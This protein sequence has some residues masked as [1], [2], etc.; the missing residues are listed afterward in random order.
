MTE[1]VRYPRPAVLERI[2]IDRPTVIEASAGTGKTYTLEHLV[3]ELLLRGEASIEE[4]LI[5]TFTEKAT[6]E[7]RQRVRD[8]IGQLLRA[9][10]GDAGLAAAG[11]SAWMLDDEARRRLR[12]AFMRFDR[13]PISTI[14]GFCQRVLGEHAFY[15]GGLFA[16]ELVDG[17]SLFERAL[18]AEVREALAGEGALRE[19]LEAGFGAGDPTRLEG[20]LFGWFQERGRPMPDPPEP[21]SSV[22]LLVH[23]LLPR[24][25][26][27]LESLKRRTGQLDFDDL[28]LRLH[29]ALHGPGGDA[30]A[31]R[32]R[33]MYRHCLVDEFQDT[34]RVQWDIFR[35][36]FLTEEGGHGLFVIGDPKQAIY[37]FRGGDIHTYLAARDALAD[38]GERVPLLDNYR[39]TE[40]AVAAQNLLFGEGFF[41]GDIRYEP[42]RCGNPAR[43]LEND[44]GQEVPP[45]VL[46]QV[47]DRKRLTA[48]GIRTTFA[49]F[50]AREIR[51]IVTDGALRSGERETA[52]PFAYSDVH[53]LTRTG[54]EAAEVG[55][56]LRRH[57]VP[58]A[59]FKQEGLLQT[60]E[61][62]HVR[63]V[64]R[65]VADPGDRARRL[66]A[67]LTP[68]FGVRLEDLSEVREAEETH[69]LVARLHRWKVLAD[70]HDYVGLFRDL[71]EQ[72][73]LVRREVFLE[74]SERAL[75]NYLHLFELLL[76]QAH[77]RRRGL[78]E[79]VAH[80]S[81][82]IERRA[83]PA[84]EDANVQRL[85]SE[86]DAVQILTMHKAKGLEAK[87]VFVA[88]G[89][90]SRPGHGDEPR[91]CH[92]DGVREAW[93]GAAPDEVEEAIRRE[94][95][96]EDERLL[97]VAVTRA[98]A[99]LY[100]PYL[101]PPARDRD[102]ARL[103]C[104]FGRMNGCYKRLNDRLVGL[105]EREAAPAT[106]FART[107][108]WVGGAPASEPAEAAPEAGASAGPW[109]PPQALLEPL[110]D[111]GEGLHALRA[112][113]A[114]PL[115]TSYTRLKSGQGGGYVAPEAEGES[116]TGETHDLTPPEADP[117]G[118][119]GGSGVGVFLH[120]VLEALD[121]E[122]VREADDV[123]GWAAREEVR[124]AFRASARRN[125][126]NVAHVPEA[127][128]LVFGALRVPVDVGPLVLPSGLCGL[129]HR[130]AEMS[131]HYPLPEQGHPLLCEPRP[132]PDRWPFEVRRGYVRGVVD[133]VFE[134]EGRLYFL[135]WKSDRLPSWS[136]AMVAQ[137]V[138]RNYTLQARLYALGVLRLL[139][140]RTAEDYEARFGG[141]LYC[142][143]RGMDGS[144]AA[145]HFERPSWD[146]VLGWESALRAEHAFGYR[147]GRGEAT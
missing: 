72:S 33:S 9:R 81:A 48:D 125:G 130:V 117:S 86:R 58:H 116:F 93:L 20:D 67:W 141:L 55:E 106:L 25:R 28:L 57:G 26:E 123:D 92:R 110:A 120:E 88:G 76:A 42:V 139:D 134:H 131:F 19:V 138:E 11:D 31:E 56:A 127:Q 10:P 83:A 135:D 146:D 2:R 124:A 133:L 53:V 103:E 6:R 8:T 70:A 29:E 77:R 41:E 98:K 95:R 12:D 79:L 49:E 104:T 14:H 143:L 7:M 100:L 119:P 74:R 132:S 18:R 121:F 32:L 84:G 39:S 68:F 144:S 15:S 136:A 129:G 147:F 75:T 89:F 107:R 118:L 27:R 50:T 85:E 1:V 51:R 108:A 21:G 69:P 16:Q 112:A 4:I 109:V 34:D 3:V 96:E 38:R 82:L 101:G 128:R 97:Y 60:A 114:G 54:K 122:A 94:A 137:H 59:F 61:A 44:A 23:E 90:T 37:G 142:F 30:L 105:V 115:V 47:V 73:G 17:R 13:A 71:L 111:P 22:G 145:V 87:V 126:V 40:R 140:A 66:R 45:V 78:P 46:V 35:R 91:V 65:A 99:R 102:G 63:D 36:I 113:R 80:L 64:L 62:R 52:E 24:V 43:V 5:V